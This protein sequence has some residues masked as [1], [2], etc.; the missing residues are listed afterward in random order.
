MA[1]AYGIQLG[2]VLRGHPTKAITTTC[3]SFGA[4]DAQTGMPPGMPEGAMCVRRFDDSLNSA[5]HITYR[6]SLRSS[7]MREPRDPLLKVFAGSLRGTEACQTAVLGNGLQ[8]T[9]P[10]RLP[11]ATRARTGAWP[12]QVYCCPGEATRIST[13]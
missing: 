1:P 4:R 6:I 2:G 13:Q 12:G 5:I 7:S 3:V 11:G 8:W 10:G 9:F